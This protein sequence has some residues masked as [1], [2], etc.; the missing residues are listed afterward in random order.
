MKLCM[1][2]I[3]TLPL[4]LEDDLPAFSAAG[5]RNIELSI[6][7]VDRYI[8]EH[9]I[10]QLVDLLASL[11]LHASGAIGLAPSGPALLLARGEAWNSYLPTLQSQFE[12]CSKLGIEQIGIGA[13]ASKWL[14][15]DKWHDNAVRNIR[16]A[17]SIADDYGLRIGLEFMSLGTPVGPFVLDNLRETRELVE[18]V[19]HSAVGYNVDFF[20][21]Y[22]SGGTVAELRAVK[23]S[24]LVS[25]HV[26]DVTA[27]EMSA[28]TDSD[29]LLPGE[30]VAPVRDYRD[31]LREAGYQDYWVLELLNE[32]LWQ[33]EPGDV[34]RLGKE[35]MERFASE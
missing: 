23:A 14:E 33:R 10:Q 28:L 4:K 11:E 24:D 2:Q 13:D 26:T 31:A 8:D 22:R 3:T 6:E 12:L 1:S 27:G 9:S 29:R 19:G 5:F 18:R 17:A 15:D 30:G 34:A 35:A 32:E 21:H 16:E 25:V 7:K 20:H